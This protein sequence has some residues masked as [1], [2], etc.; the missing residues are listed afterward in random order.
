M[1]RPS[2]RVYTRIGTRCPHRYR[3]PRSN[4]DYGRTRQCLKNNKIKNWIRDGTHMAS[5]EKRRNINYVD[6]DTRLPKKCVDK[7]NEH[8]LWFTYFDGKTGP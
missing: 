4:T 7:D 6:R 5:G 3:C 8:F 1:S 2:S